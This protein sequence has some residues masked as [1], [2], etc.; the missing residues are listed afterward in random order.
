VGLVWAIA[1]SRRS[2][3]REEVQ[4]DVKTSNLPAAPLPLLELKVPKVGGKPMVVSSVECDCFD[5]EGQEAVRLELKLHSEVQDTGCEGWKWIN[6]LIEKAALDRA[7]QFVPVST[8]GVEKY[9]QVIELPRS[10]GKLKS[11]ELLG[12]YGSNLVRIPPEIGEM[13]SLVEFDPYTSYRLHWMPY[14]IVRCSKLRQSRVST[15]T[16]YG[17]YTYRVPF[18][19]LPQDPGGIGQGTDSVRRCSVCDIRPA[20][21]GFQVWLSANPA[22]DVLPLLVN[23]CSQECVDR[24]PPA[25]DGYI[26][27]PHRGGLDLEQPPPEY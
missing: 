15:R 14:E 1:R 27:G 25:A 13:S 12:L 6:E 9:R 17:N 11:V 8:M 16:L 2:R 19:R 26:R 4:V 3:R 24:L 23:A 10:I 20:V 18:P 21:P 7:K 5:D 22:R